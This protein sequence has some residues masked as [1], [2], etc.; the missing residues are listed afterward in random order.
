[1]PLS[2]WNSLVVAVAVTAINLMLGSLAGYAYS[3]HARSRLIGGSLW[4]LMMTRMT[5]SL[6]LILPFFIVFQT[7]GPD[8]HAH[9]R[10]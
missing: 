8:R 9:R 3:R 7:L 1:M 10:W 6:A 5:P 2:I 4:A